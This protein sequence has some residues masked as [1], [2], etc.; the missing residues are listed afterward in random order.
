MAPMI[1]QTLLKPEA[2]NAQVVSLCR[3]ACVYGFA[4]VCIN[5][6]FIKAAVEVL[7]GSAVKPCTV[8]G[9]PTGAVTTRTK[10]GEAGEAVVSGAMELDMVICVGH[11]KERNFAYVLSDIKAVVSEAGGCCVKVILETCLLTDDEKVTACELVVDAGAQFVKTSTGLA[12]GGAT[13]EDV[14]LMRRIVGPSFGVKASGGIRTLQDALTMRSAGA[15][16]IGT[17]AGVAIVTSRK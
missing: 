13:V 5:P 9:F 10:Q 2:T 3:E 12:G 17:S 16:R 15:N 6:V 7:A 1:D 11:L 14:R 4:S 8:I